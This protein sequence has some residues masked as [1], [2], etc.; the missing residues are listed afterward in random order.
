MLLKCYHHLHLVENYDVKSTEHKSYEV[1]RVDIFEMI[2]NTS[3]LVAE[4]VNKEFL[5]LRRFKV[6]P[7]KIKWP[8]QWRRK[9]EST[10][11]TVDFLG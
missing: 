4:L 6:D 5:I 2:A 9:H 10:I 1:N 11:P 8:L 7:T 3:E